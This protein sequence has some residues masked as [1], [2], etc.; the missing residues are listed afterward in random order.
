MNAR[1]T[2]QVHTA[3]TAQLR[4]AHTTQVHTAHTTQVHSTQHMNTHGTSFTVPGEVTTD[5]SVSGTVLGQAK[6]DETEGDG[7]HDTGQ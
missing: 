3:H 1:H 4:T 2:E 7:Q 6:L 5:L